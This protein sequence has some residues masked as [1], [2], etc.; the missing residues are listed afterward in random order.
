MS[1]INK[2]S[3]LFGAMVLSGCA[4]VPV[5][6]G[7]S[8]PQQ[9]NASF[10]KIGQ[11]VH[12]V[13]GGLVHL[14]AN[15]TS[16]F[17]Y[18][19][20]TPISMRFMLGRLNVSNEEMLISATLQNNPVFCTIRRTY[21]DPLV[22]AT[23][24]ACFVEGEKGAFDKVKVAPGEYWFTKDLPSP[25]QFLAVELPVR[26]AGHALKRELVFE[27]YQ[28]GSLFFTE[29]YYEYN[30]EA[31]SKAKPVLAKIGAIPARVILSDAI[32]NVIAVTPNSL[33]Y[34]LERSWD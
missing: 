17:N 12:V 3:L 7:D 1:L 2:L 33:T 13:V 24:P 18:R 5:V 29:K 4:A 11:Q 28:N 31:A 19:L 27:G 30:L 20:K 23:K 6:S 21:S 14:R 22:G 16:Q 9:K 25:V 34:T 10:P 32:I 26:Q 8:V 15:Y